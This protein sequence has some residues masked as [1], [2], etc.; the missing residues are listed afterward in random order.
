MGKIMAQHLYWVQF[1]PTKQGEFPSKHLAIVLPLNHDKTTCRVLP[2]TRSSRGLGGN[3]ISLGTLHT[4]PDIS[5]AV[6]DQ[7]R[8]VSFTR[9]SQHVENGHTID[10][11]VPDPVFYKVK[12]ALMAWEERNLSQDQLMQF[13][14]DRLI[15]LKKKHIV[16][17][18][19]KLKRTND[20]VHD[21]EVKAIKRAIETQIYH[22]IDVHDFIS[23]EH[24][25]L[26]PYLEEVNVS[27]MA[28]NLE[29]V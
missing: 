11:K 29:T 28:F 14:S 1:N 22:L 10:I 24:P 17:L 9:M 27:V 15:T 23:N 8:T 19:Y 13:Y 7:V 3:K 4:F 16:N 25:H 12:T 20:A 5:Y 21:D 26:L 18:L 6:L 2:L